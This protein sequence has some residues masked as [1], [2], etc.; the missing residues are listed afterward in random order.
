MPFAELSLLASSQQSLDQDTRHALLSLEIAL[1]DAALW[2]QVTNLSARAPAHVFRQQME[3]LVDLLGKAGIQTDDSRARQL[4][5]S[6]LRALRQTGSVPLADSCAKAPLEDA[7]ANDLTHLASPEPSHLTAALEQVGRP[8][9]AQLAEWRTPWGE[10]LLL[11]MVDYFK[12]RGQPHQPHLYRPA[13]P[14]PA[15]GAWRCLDLIG[16]LLQEDEAAVV[17]LLERPDQSSASAAPADPHEEVKRL[18]ELA[19]TRFRQGNYEQAAGHFTAALKLDPANASLYR[20]RGEV[21]RLLCEYE[22][23]IADLSVALRLQPADPGLLV[24][25]GLVFHFSGEQE[26]AIADCGKALELDQESVAAYRARASACAEAELFEQALADLD[27]VLRRTPFDDGALYLRGMIHFKQRRLSLAIA[28]FDRT[29][30]QNPYH[31]QALLHR[32]HAHRFRGDQSRAIQDYSAVLRH[33]LD[34]VVALGG[35]GLAH[36]L[37]GNADRAIADFSE[38]LRLEPHNARAYYHRGVLYRTRGDLVS[39]M[40][41]L[42]A[43]IRGEPYNWAALYYRGK[44]ALTQGQYPLAVLD[45]TAVVRLNPRCVAGYL[46]RAL[47]Y[48]CLGQHLEGV[49]DSTRAIELNVSAAAAYLVRGVVHAHKADYEAAIA[50]L[51]EAIRLDER[52][53][54]A[55]HERSMAHTLQGDHDHALADCSRLV[56]LEPGNAQAYVSRSA[57]YHC[58]GEVESALA[59]YARAMEIDPRCILTGFNP[60][61]AQTAR[62]RITQRLSDYIDGLREYTPPLDQ[63]A[64][65]MRIVLPPLEK[66]RQ[67]RNT[68][69]DTATQRSPVT[70]HEVAVEP[71]SPQAAQPPLKP[72][73]PKPASAPAIAATTPAPTAQDKLLDRPK[74]KVNQSSDTVRAPFPAAVTT[75]QVTSRPAAPSQKPWL[76]ENEYRQERPA[77]DPEAPNAEEDADAQ[78]GEW[79]AANNVSSTSAPKVNWVSDEPAAHD[80]DDEELRAKGN[81]GSSGSQP[82]KPTA[83]PVQ[84]AYSL[85]V[86]SL[87]AEAEPRK[88]YRPSRPLPRKHED[89]EDEPS[90]FQRWRKPLPMGSSIAAGLLLLYFFF[91]HNLFG[92]SD[93]VRVYPAQGTVELDGQP[94][95]GA[96]IFLQPLEGTNPKVPRP[97]ATTQ[98]D[99]TFELGTYHDDDGAPPGEYKVTVQLFSRQD[100]RHGGQTLNFLPARYARPETT[101]LTLQIHEGE[102]KLP[103]LKLTRGH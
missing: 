37:K 93:K 17:A 13:L 30:K 22:R 68:T 21:Y 63:S 103:V 69:D 16:A 34:N 48:D 51:T 32:A 31:V 67:A 42:D 73:L 19:I 38:T 97:R 23:A 6:G 88:P 96:A 5:A 70:T 9:V 98:E 89:D 80:D 57:V 83:N 90:L 7:P 101:D 43:A 27:Q 44:I 76:G 94:L 60:G 26:R 45:L 77:A 54:L 50:D 28:D 100:A 91:P 20:Q 36:K 3:A 84:Q 74:S 66:V 12:R 92:N 56:A 35:R 39:A 24:S 86:S 78:I 75:P 41:D 71:K 79:L 82:A 18:C 40:A 33:Q 58:K 14:D 55:Y 53:A 15:D 49:A 59:D 47:A 25:R 65:D 99:G 102:N 10:S 87:S 11:G 4:L 81:A 61:L 29:L 95:A 2:R 85:L 62:G 1:G 64:A 8:D 72:D 46:S 52:L